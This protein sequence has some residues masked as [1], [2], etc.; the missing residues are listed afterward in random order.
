MQQVLKE[1]GLWQSG[2]IMKCESQKGPDGKAMK[3]STDSC[4]AKRILQLQPDF[5]EQKSLVQEVIEA[6]GY[7][8]IFLPKFML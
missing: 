5:A 8:C 2:L 4:C 3:C 7:Y 6:A 1:C